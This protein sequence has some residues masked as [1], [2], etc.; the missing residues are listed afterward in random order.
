MGGMIMPKVFR[1]D[2]CGRLCGNIPHSASP[3]KRGYAC[4]KCYVEQV[5]PSKKWKENRFNWYANK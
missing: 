3:Y 1:C 2:I 4:D 5:I